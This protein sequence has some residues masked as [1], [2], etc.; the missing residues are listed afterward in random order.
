[1]NDDGHAVWNL[2]LWHR[3]N[4]RIFGEGNWVL[5]DRCTAQNQNRVV[6][7]HRLAHT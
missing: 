5:C 4:D 1:M 2:I 3:Y 7:H 6:F